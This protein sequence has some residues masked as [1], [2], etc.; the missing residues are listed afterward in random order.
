MLGY[1]GGAIIKYVVYEEIRNYAIRTG[2][3]VIKR[4]LYTS[5][6]YHRL[7]TDFI[8]KTGYTF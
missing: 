3:D 8:R 2:K 6:T 7:K 1:I 5:I 4:K